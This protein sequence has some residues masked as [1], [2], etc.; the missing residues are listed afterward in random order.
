MAKG[1]AQSVPQA[2][3][4]TNLSLSYQVLYWIFLVFYRVKPPTLAVA[5]IFFWQYSLSMNIKQQDV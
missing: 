4:G 1:E 2:L 5:D 3:M